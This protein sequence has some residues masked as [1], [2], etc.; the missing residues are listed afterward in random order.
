L[1]S[2]GAYVVGCSTTA[3]DSASVETTTLP[4]GVT[5]TTTAL[6]GGPT[7][8]LASGG[9]TSTVKL[10]FIHHSSGG[11]W[12]H[13]TDDEPETAGGLGASL[14]ANNYYVTE[15]DYAWFAGSVHLGYNTDFGFWTT[16]FTTTNMAYVYANNSNYY[17]TNTITNPGGEN[18]IVMFKGC[19]PNS[20]LYGNPTDAAATGATNLI[21]EQTTGDD[22]DQPAAYSVANCKWVYNQILEYCRA[23]PDKLFIAVTSPPR[24]A[25]HYV[26]ANAANARAFNNW[27]VNDWLTGYSAT[28]GVH[29]V[30]VFDFYNVL[31]DPDNHHRISSGAVQHHTEVDSLNTAYYPTIA[32][33]GDDHPNSAGNQ[34]AT[35]E[36]VPLLNYYYLRWQ[37]SR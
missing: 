17:Y 20:N 8:T 25:G 1:A 21:Q 32:G 7:T 12:L 10:C 29:N 4:P 34:K 33:G 13:N 35:T 9:G 5:T 6:V 31:T 24:T 36:F 18:Q 28:G 15:T 14:N 2:V 22:A 27:L 16:W 19:F 23:R 26:G 11:N 3:T 30:A 37:A